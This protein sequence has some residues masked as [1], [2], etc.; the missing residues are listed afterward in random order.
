MK[1]FVII[2]YLIVYLGIALLAA[3]SP[4]PS[5][6][7]VV[8]VELGQP[9]NG[10]T[11]QTGSDFRLKPYNQVKSHKARLRAKKPKTTTTT[12]STTSTTTTTT[13]QTPGEQEEQNNGEQGPNE[14]ER[15]SGGRQEEAAE[16]RPSSNESGAEETTLAEKETR[17]ESGT[18]TANEGRQSKL[19]R[20]RGEK[21]TSKVTETETEEREQQAGAAKE[22]SPN[23]R[24]G[25]SSGSDEQ[26]LDD[27]KEREREKESRGEKLTKGD[28]ISGKS[29]TRD[30]TPSD[31]A[32][33]GGGGETKK[34]ANPKTQITNWG[35]FIALPIVALIIISALF[36]LIRKLWNKYKGKEGR[37]SS[38][39]LGGFADLKNIQILGQQYKEKV[40][41]ESEQLAANMELNEEAN[42]KDDSKKDE[43]KLG[44]LQ[45]RLDYDFNSTNLAVG[46]LAAEELPGMDMCGTSDPYVKVY[47]MPDKK[48]KFETKVH[49]K[50]LN[51]VFNETFNFK[52]PY[53]E[54]TTKTLVFAVYDFD[55]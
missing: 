25:S 15:L 30:R 29:A 53:A 45:F 5:S 33:G 1:Y 24:P 2:I 41:P 8:E 6:D 4:R 17:D 3:S 26:E 40:Q 50:T 49:R 52:V 22:E 48:K 11:A 18:E 19:G 10:N 27:E 12:T 46:V 51:P 16:N 54:V 32:S 36:I 23:S 13:T 42:D 44:R 28:K 21:V 38:A 55:R 31:R 39:G 20:H 9:S 35:M 7:H 37:G 14:T 34:R 47:L 43:D